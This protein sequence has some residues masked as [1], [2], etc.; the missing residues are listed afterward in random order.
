MKIQLILNDKE[1]IIESD[2]AQMLSDVLRRENLISVKPGCLSHNCG[3]CYVLLDNKAVPSCHIP[4]GIIMG[5]KITTLEYFSKSDFYA[6]IIKGF[7]KA[8]VSMCG[9]CNAGKIFLAY[10]VINSMHEP[11]R[12]KVE[13]VTSRLIDCCV[14]Q[15]TLING[16]LY[17]YSIHFDKEKLRKNGNR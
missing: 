14:E 5:E 7:E 8:G 10:E 6:D 3:S 17:A 9:F 16:I 11:S 4:V 2:P 15:N 1:C 13:V 12:D